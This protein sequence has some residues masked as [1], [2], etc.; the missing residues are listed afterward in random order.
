[1]KQLMELSGNEGYDDVLVFA[2]VAS[3]IEQETVSRPGRMSQLLCRP[4]RPEL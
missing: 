1:M 3:V 4:I 2:P